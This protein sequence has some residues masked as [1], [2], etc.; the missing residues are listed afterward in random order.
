MQ[1]NVFASKPT[2]RSASRLPALSGEM[3]ISA[4]EIAC[5]LT[6]GLL[7]AVAVGFGN[8]LVRGVPGHAILRGVLPIALGMALVPR[9]SAGITMSLSAGVAAAAMSWQGI[10]RFQPAA[11]LGV[12]LLGPVLDAALTDRAQGWRLYARF[13]V[14]GAIA[15]LLAFTTRFSLAY[16]GWQAGGGGGGGGRG[17][18][19][20]GRVFMTFWSSALGS[21][22]LCGALAGLISAAIWFRLRA[23]ETQ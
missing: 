15:N 18:T 3:E 14:A 4:G 23:K 6:C 20:G 22:V 10:G 21:F 17:G 11:V 1:M 7:A 5:L 9:R 2:L 12:V 8:Q 19:G 13:I 16:F